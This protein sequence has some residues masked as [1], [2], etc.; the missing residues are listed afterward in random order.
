MTQWK[1]K[2]IS[3]K[4]TAWKKWSFSLKERTETYALWSMDSHRV[5]CCYSAMHQGGKLFCF[6]LISVSLISGGASQ[7][8]FLQQSLDSF[9][10]L[11]LDDLRNKQNRAFFQTIC[12]EK[13]KP[14]V[15]GF[16]MEVLTKLFRAEL[17]KKKKK[18][19]S[20]TQ[21]RKD[22]FRNL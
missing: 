5:L 16:Q 14:T 22:V 18:V 2:V 20:Y 21:S 15:Y 4:E 13:W 11:D 19:E 17:P 10:S 1:H 8:Q 6:L 9:F 12:E 3:H 7:K